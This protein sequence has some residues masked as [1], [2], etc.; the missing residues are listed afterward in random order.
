MTRYFGCGLWA[1]EQCR[2]DQVERAKKNRRR[3]EN[4]KSTETE[5]KAYEIERRLGESIRTVTTIGLQ[6]LGF[7]RYRR[8]YWVRRN[9]RTLPGPA[10]TA[11]Q[12]K[13]VRAEI[14]HAVDRIFDGDFDAADELK[15]LADRHPRIVADSIYSDLAYHAQKSLLGRDE[16]RARQSREV[17]ARMALIAGELAGENPSPARRLVSEVAGFAYAEFWLVSLGVAHAGIDRELPLYNKRR[18]AAQKRFLQAVKTVS[19]IAALERPKRVAIFR[20]T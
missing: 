11:E 9:M 14:Q 1:Y 17:M 12:E 2:L 3:R 5:R 15:R 6:A 10:L 4:R 20:E 8:G 13:A 18:T 7:V 19:Q 16:K